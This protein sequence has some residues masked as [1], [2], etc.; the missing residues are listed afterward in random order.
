MNVTFPVGWVGGTVTIEGI[1]RVGQVIS[2]TFVNPG[3]GGTVVGQVPFVTLSNFTNSA[4]AGGA[5]TS[6]TIVTRDAY[7]V[8]H[9]NV[10]AFLKV[11][12]DGTIDSF[13]ISDT[14]NGVFEPSGNHHGNHGIEVWY[15]YSHTVTQAAHSHTASTAT[16][17]AS[18][19]SHA[20]GVVV[21]D[22]G[23]SHGVTDPG[24][25]HTQNGHTHTLS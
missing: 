24:H 14:V 10:V 7:A 19:A 9:D 1:G 16:T 21:T 4:P 17:G 8:P 11:S 25:V 23:H 2:E 6:A 5:G 12:I 22:S 18:V 20:T 3:G 13:N 15:T